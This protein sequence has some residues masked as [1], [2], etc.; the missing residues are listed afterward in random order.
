MHL[1]PATV[2]RTTVTVEH[3]GVRTVVA[4]DTLRAAAHQGDRAL[5]QTY[6]AVWCAYL[7]ATEQGAVADRW[8]AAERVGLGSC[9]CDLLAVGIDRRVATRESVRA[10]VDLAI[11]ARRM[12]A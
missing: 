3:L 11:L 4:I 2:T 12:A 5:R 10:Q 9:A 6:G 7:R 8:L 1:V